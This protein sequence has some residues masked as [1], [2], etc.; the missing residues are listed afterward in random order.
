[1]KDRFRTLDEKPIFS[2]TGRK[3]KDYADKSPAYSL[4]PGDTLAWDG[5]VSTLY[6]IEEWR[7]T[8][9]AIGSIV[10]GTPKKL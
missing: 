8:K 6:F 3:K 10:T 7:K 1:M 4:E 5:F 9:R 2:N